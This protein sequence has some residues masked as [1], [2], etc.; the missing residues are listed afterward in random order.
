MEVISSIIWPA[1]ALIF[2]VFGFGFGKWHPAWMIFP[3][4]GVAM[5]IIESIVAAVGKK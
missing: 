3:I 4:L 5:G 2:L 1:A